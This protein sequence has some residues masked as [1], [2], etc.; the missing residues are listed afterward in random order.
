VILKYIGS[1]SPWQWI[2][3]TGVSPGGPSPRAA[4]VRHSF[5]HWRCKTKAN[6]TNI[7]MLWVVAYHSQ[8]WLGACYIY[9]ER[10]RW[11]EPPQMRCLTRVRKTIYKL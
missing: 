8:G 3:S 4:L 1:G 2:D 9:R 5:S 6:Q 11:H 10:E 7:Q